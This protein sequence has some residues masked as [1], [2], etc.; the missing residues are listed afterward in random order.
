MVAPTWFHACT[1]PQCGNLHPDEA[2]LYW[3]KKKK[4]NPYY[5]K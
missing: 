3:K 5:S 2:A 1:Q 4:I